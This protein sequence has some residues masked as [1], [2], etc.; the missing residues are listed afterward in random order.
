MPHNPQNERVYARLW[1]KTFGCDGTSSA[2][3]M[4]TSRKILK[5][6]DNTV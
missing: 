1:G 5:W 3:Q 6:R 4:T 2:P